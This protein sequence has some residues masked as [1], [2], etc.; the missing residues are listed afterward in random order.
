MMNTCSMM[1][2]VILTHCTEDRPLHSTTRFHVDAVR[3]VIC[4]SDERSLFTHQLAC[5]RWKMHTDL[6]QLESL[7]K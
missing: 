1:V 5:G 2:S 6:V 7:E 3:V 4:S